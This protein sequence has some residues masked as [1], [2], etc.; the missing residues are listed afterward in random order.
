M[1]VLLQQ[2]WGIHI[3][4]TYAIGL[5]YTQSRP[6]IETFTFA[7]PVAVISLHQEVIN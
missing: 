3:L 2:D 6:E 7:D 5:G 4:C 1:N